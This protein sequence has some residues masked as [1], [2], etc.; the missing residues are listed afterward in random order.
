MNIQAKK[1]ELIEEFL[2]ISDESLIL[3]LEA[4]L[5]KE[6]K[7][8]MYRNIKPMTINEFREMIDTALKDSE[9]GHILTHR[10][11]EERVKSWK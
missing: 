4:F 6:K 8:S 1:L 5:K 2:R 10:D 7:S 3:K 9:N 11:L